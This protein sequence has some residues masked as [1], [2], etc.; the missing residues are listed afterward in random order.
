[1]L[2]FTV[3]CVH[4]YLYYINYYLGPMAWIQK[5]MQ[6]GKNPRTLLSELL[7]DGTVIPE[8][9]HDVMLWKII[10]SLLSDPP[11]RKKLDSV[12]TLD[13]LVQ[14]IRKCNKI[15]VLTGAGVSLALYSTRFI[16]IE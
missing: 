9:V 4:M 10:V 6:E 8:G 3:N 16:Q 14:L 11:K 2:I 12:N 7:P 5:Q 1:M 15:V 13:D